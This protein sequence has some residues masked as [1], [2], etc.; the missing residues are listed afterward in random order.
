MEDEAELN[1]QLRGM[2]R[3]DDFEDE[4]IW[5][6]VGNVAAAGTTSSR[7]HYLEHL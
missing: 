2:K 6:G 7:I 3:L 5:K 4:S 1:A